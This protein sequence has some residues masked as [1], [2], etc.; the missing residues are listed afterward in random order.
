MGKAA[1][2]LL[3][4]EDV[5]SCPDASRVGED[6]PDALP[7]APVQVEVAGQLF[8]WRPGEGL[9]PAVVETVKGW[10]WRE[11][12]KFEFI[13]SSNF[14]LEDLAQEGFVGALVGAQRFNPNKNVKYLTYAAFWVRQALLEAS[15]V[16]H[17]RIPRGQFDKL[18]KANRLP[19]APVSLDAPL[20]GVGD[21]T[22]ADTVLM[23]EEGPEAHGIA[24]VHGSME[25]F[26][27]A[28]EALSE[29]DRSIL[30]RRFGLDGGKSGTLKALGEMD[31]VSR[32][33]VRQR[34][35][36]VMERFREILAGAGVTRVE[37]LKLHPG[38]IDAVFGCL[39]VERISTLAQRRQSLCKARIPVP[40]KNAKARVRQAVAAN[41]ERDSPAA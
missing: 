29:E 39:D 9:D 19:N 27:R 20:P 5:E 1:A 18:K 13:C 28:L 3:G 23:V 24:E 12:R 30:V 11:A 6:K 2:V 14:T 36:Y 10:V 26:A 16:T 22:M 15:K 32:E 21:L 33:R 17:V 40:R 41:V 35:K 38:G 37:D 7:T 4:G 31:G 25:V 34:E 8:W